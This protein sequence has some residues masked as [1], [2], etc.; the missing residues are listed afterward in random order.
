MSAEAFIWQKMLER[1]RRWW[2]H[3]ADS[4]PLRDECARFVPSA[5]NPLPRLNPFDK[6]MERAYLESLGAPQP[7]L[8]ARL[9]NVEELLS[10][11]SSLPR[12]WVLK[13]V[14]AA[15]SCLLYT[16]PSPRDS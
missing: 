5:A 2:E 8:L 16:S 14:G 4:K 15:Y 6:L 3:G 13:P 11:A 9:D 7:R 10:M 12:S 1:Q